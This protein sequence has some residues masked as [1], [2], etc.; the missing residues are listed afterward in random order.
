MK[1]REARL[2][3]RLP[4]T[5]MLMDSHS[6]GNDKVLRLLWAINQLNYRHRSTVSRTKFAF[7][8]T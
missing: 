6:R 5:P 3:R 8:N 1:R 2:N 7:Q 4:S